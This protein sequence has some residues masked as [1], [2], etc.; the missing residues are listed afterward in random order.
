MPRAPGQLTP[1]TPTQFKTVNVGWTVDDI[2]AIPKGGFYLVYGRFIEI[3][4]DGFIDDPGFQQITG[5]DGQVLTDN[6]SESPTFTTRETPFA[7][8]AVPGETYR[9]PLRL[10]QPEAILEVSCRGVDRSGQPPD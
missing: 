8:C 1:T 3:S 2:T 9:L 7:V 4:F 10:R 5:T 6:R